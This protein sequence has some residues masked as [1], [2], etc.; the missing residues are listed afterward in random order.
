MFSDPGLIALGVSI[1]VVLIFCG[2][3]L[4]RELESQGHGQMPRKFGIKVLF[5][6][7]HVLV[8]LLLVLLVHF[9]YNPGKVTHIL[10]SGEI[11]SI[12]GLLEAPDEPPDEPADGPG[13]GP[14]EGPDGEEDAIGFGPLAGGTVVTGT[15]LFFALFG[16]GRWRRVEA[17][18]LRQL[19]KVSM[20][21]DDVL[22]LA[23]NLRRCGLDSVLLREDAGQALDRIQR[24]RLP[25]EADDPTRSL[26][27]QWAKVETLLKIWEADPHW[28]RTLP[29]GETPDL[30][31]TRAAHDRR[32]KLA[33][34]VESQIQ[35]IEQGGADPRA[36]AQ[37][38]EEIRRE[39]GEPAIS[40]ALEGGPERADASGPPNG[41][42]LQE[43][44][45]PLVEYFVEEYAALLSLWSYASAKSVMLA[46]DRAEGRLQQLSDRGFSGIG[47]FVP[48]QL[49]RAFLIAGG[50]FLASI[51]IFWGVPLLLGALG[52]SGP[53]PVGGMLF[54]I[55][56]NI[57]LAT[58]LGAIV[59]GMR[60]LAK[61]TVT[62][63]FTYGVAALAIGVAYSVISFTAISLGVSPIGGSQAEP[64][65]PAF[66]LCLA[67][68]PFSLVLGICVLART[69]SSRGI[70]AQRFL[71][72]LRLAAFLVAAGFLLVV[73]TT[74]LE[75][76]PTGPGLGVGER[77]VVVG[78]LT[79]VLGLVIGGLV[80]PHVRQAALSSV[81]VSSKLG[82]P[83]PGAADEGAEASRE[84]VREYAAVGSG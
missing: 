22:A 16:F 23:R 15:S 25:G 58:V 42:T 10:E 8:L 57:S 11:S 52:T 6:A 56:F 72:A 45:G 51:P 77:I 36:L 26:L 19:Q 74:A 63:W 75:A 66:F 38:R 59:G 7:G 14:S 2:H 35:Q 29:E 27:L 65:P 48:I 24:R 50:V 13:A 39:E 64:P 33:L 61:A 5:A 60:A 70:R 1:V 32:S 37:L 80:V 54:V 40:R 18:V 67:I 69:D 9:G 62:P 76:Q 47:D 55:A 31:A 68:I 46:G 30:E 81:V 21:E 4:P 34:R 84:E 71:D 79:A 53:R 43:L 49:H 28:A 12:P 44:L 82:D 17:A 78:A 41:D 83:A 3:F 20:V 73:M